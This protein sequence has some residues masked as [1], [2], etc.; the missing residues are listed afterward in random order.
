MSHAAETG[1]ARAGVITTPHGQIQTP[2]FI[3]VGTKA[4]V[5]TVLPEAMNELGAQALLANAYHLYLQPGPSVLDE[6]GGLGAFMNWD[7]PT[8]T[9]SGG[10]QVLSLG[11]GFKK[12]LAMD[13]QTFRS[14]QVIAKNK[15]RLAHVDDEGVT[16]KSHLDGSMHR[17]TSEI[18]MQIQH[19]LGADIMFAFDECTTLHNTR[20]YQELAL[21]RTYDWAIR[22]LDEHKKLT[23]QRA[24][25]PYQALFGVIQGAQ[26]EDLRKKAAADLGG[27]SSSGIEFD[28]F[29]IGGAL[30]KD[31][32]GTIVG[33]VNS[34]LPQEKPKHLLGI[35][36]PE[37]LFV[38][39]ENGVD[40]FDCVLASRIARTSS[41]Y[42]M[43]GRFNMSNAPYVRDFNPI[44][45]E[46]DCYTCK[47]YTRAYLCH[48][49][50]GKEMLA[51]TLA[52]I[53]N[54]RFIVRLVDQM[55]IA[56]I[57]GTFAEMKKE[58]MGRYTHKSGQ[59]RN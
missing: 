8:F 6:A 1:L 36:A 39:V 58:F 43:T 28:G 14:D 51:G 59:A 23:D 32:L 10:F 54:E 12:V 47:N 34:T 20:P 56:I 19:Q 53:H 30:D 35:G 16:F 11:V 50:R 33:W 45:D 26:Y 37:D 25:K 4:N 48:L 46:C 21:S 42:T 24:N 3:P 18:S 29:G 2:A 15:E 7:K 31:S 52:T 41:V 38:G 5:K 17:F 22:C 9:D 55:R 27:M 40:T 57:D 49:F 44:D 13:A